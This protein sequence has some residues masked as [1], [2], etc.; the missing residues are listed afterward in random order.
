M[1]NS[2]D[3]KT[4]CNFC[5]TVCGGAHIAYILSGDIQPDPAMALDAAA[6]FP[7]YFLAAAVHQ[8]VSGGRILP[9]GV[10]IYLD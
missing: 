8:M 6:R 1:E 7:E 9:G 4:G 3:K 2:H 5:I 10:F